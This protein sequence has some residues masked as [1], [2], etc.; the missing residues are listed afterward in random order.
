MYSE[1]ENVK[2]MSIAANP[3]Q[4][5]EN[6]TMN[7]EFKNKKCFIMRKTSEKRMKKY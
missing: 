2:G 5:R 7:I 4:K 3:E 6:K 1:I